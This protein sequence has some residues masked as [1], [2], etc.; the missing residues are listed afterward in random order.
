MT[1]LKMLVELEL[2]DIT[3]NTND[4]EEWSWLLEEILQPKVIDDN[5]RLFL[6]S[7]DIGDT[8]GTIKVLEITHDKT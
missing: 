7:N 5:N 1:K 2:H 3:I 4:P 6:H 8:V